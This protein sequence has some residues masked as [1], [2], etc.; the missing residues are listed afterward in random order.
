MRLL[1]AY[2]LFPLMLFI[3][4]GFLVLSRA[5]FF[6]T[7]HLRISGK[8]SRVIPALFFQA[9]ELAF[10]GCLHFW[11]HRH[12]R[13][14]LKLPSLPI[15][16]FFLMLMFVPVLLAIYDFENTRHN[17]Q[18]V[19]FST[20]KAYVLNIR[21]G[22]STPPHQIKSNH[23]FDED[24]VA[25]MMAI[26]ADSPLFWSTLGAFFLVYF[27]IC[28][29]LCYRYRCL[30]LSSAYGSKT[31]NSEAESV[32]SDTEG[33]IQN[34]SEHVT[35]WLASKFQT[36]RDVN[37]CLSD[38]QWVPKDEIRNPVFITFHVLGVIH[39]L[40]LAIFM[41]FPFERQLALQSIRPFTY[42]LLVSL[43]H[44]ESRL[45]R[46]Q[47]ETFVPNVR[48]F[49][50][51]GRYWLDKRRKPR[52]PAVHGDFRAYCA[53]NPGEIEC[54][55]FV[56][57]PSP[58]PIPSVPNVVLLVY[59]SLTPS[60]Y[61]IDDE[62]LE[63]HAT[64]NSSDPHFLVTN[65]TFWNRRLMPNLRE[66]SKQSVTFS[67]VTSQGIPTFSGLHALFTGVIPSQ[68]FI[69]MI[70]GYPAHADD[71]PSFLHNENYRTM[72]LS[73]QNLDFDGIRNWAYSRSA[74]EE[75][76]IRHN[77]IEGYGELIDD[78]I[79]LSLTKIP[80]LINCSTPE[81]EQVI[82]ETT[83]KLKSLEKPKWFD[84]IASYCPARRQAAILGFDYRHLRHSNWIADRV[85]AAQFKLHWRQQREYLERTNQSRPIFAVYLNTESHVPYNGYD[86][87][88]FYHPRFNPGNAYG[89]SWRR[90]LR[91]K[92]VNHYI[93]QY[94]IKETLEYLKE[95]DPN[96][97]VIM[98]GDHSTR[99]IPI[100]STNTP[101]TDNVVYSEDCVGGSSGPDGLF[102]V[103]GMITYLGDDPDVKRVLQL[104][105]L[106]GKTVKIP[107]D[108]N[109]MVYTVMDAISKLRGHSMPPTSRRSRN[110]LD[111]SARLVNDIAQKGNEEALKPIEESGWQSLALVSFQI[112]YKNGTKVLRSHT[113]DV[114]GAHYYE[115]IA[116]PACVKSHETAPHRTGGPEAEAML[117]DAYRYM[118]HENFMF[119][120]NR[121]FHYD[122]R[123]KQCIEEG[124]CELPRPVKYKIDDSAFYVHALGNPVL[125]FLMGFVIV[126][127]VYVHDSGVIYDSLRMLKEETD[128]EEEMLE[129][130]ESVNTT[131]E[132]NG[133]SA[134]RALL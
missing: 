123:D 102:G 11:C 93:D 60:T 115:A 7:S 2:Y 25:M 66:W 1:P 120:K 124:H 54:R 49:L 125:A 117:E 96:T 126:A 91:F 41:R 134:F 74:R 86:L 61:L 97:I 38:M 107:A 108:H 63:E 35:I 19:T 43:T 16:M 131:A 73:G 128:V 95:N 116:S 55:T 5:A 89:P 75:A 39:I 67:G 10:I 122:F 4:L 37:W 31:D 26:I 129:I 50:P 98:T 76:L 132:M 72:F 46:G 6:S 88:E 34:K 24:N 103:T 71:L 99:D 64:V 118:A 8:V 18:I 44:H 110:L 87:A 30:L 48:S 127:L 94:F 27:V 119:R 36:L 90:E 23:Q 133:D 14:T 51:E 81:M 29:V 83:E 80:K 92:R 21:N 3:P 15:N 47:A 113:A 59:E 57:T 28:S 65:T 111:V 68:S 32:K 45:T 130:S 109:D 20:L 82:D 62:F 22:Y 40:S 58:T 53:Y 84:Y 78:P 42:N 105:N 17:L 52:F 85:T 114:D 33:M 100:R 79:Q 9:S 13:G 121:L 12:W 106:T 70:D 77:C 56:P 69:N 104:E 101:L 112:D